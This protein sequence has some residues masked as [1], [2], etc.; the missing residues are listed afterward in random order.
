MWLENDVEITLI[1]FRVIFL[2]KCRFS[3]SVT[4]YF[5]DFIILTVFF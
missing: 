5:F 3:L 2:I 1:A 4:F